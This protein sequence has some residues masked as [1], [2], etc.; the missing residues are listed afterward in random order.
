MKVLINCWF[1]DIANEKLSNAFLNGITELG[2][3]GIELSIDYPLL[4]RCSIPNYLV[5]GLRDRGLILS[6]HLP[7]REIYLASPISE[8]RDAAVR[9]IS[10]IIRQVS[11]L[12]PEYLITHLSTDQAFCGEDDT[13]C[14]KASL[15]SIKHLVKLSEELGVLLAVE[16]VADKCCSGEE[17]LPLILKEFD[18]LR[19]CLDIP[20]I[21]EHRLRYWGVTTSVKEVIN[22]LAPIMFDRLITIHIHG[23]KVHNG[24]AISHIIPSKEFLSSL[25]EG[26]KVKISNKPKY[27]VIEVFRDVNGGP[28]RDINKLR[29]IISYLR[30]W[31]K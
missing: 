13:D 9:T 7:W 2:F 29:W 14:V 27:A 23:L 21:I 25:L 8:V 31:R 10:R 18:R 1:K 6:V 20:H 22:D 24:M 4:F 28:L 17:K 11:R 30:R 3:D 12:G 5:N 15:E 19:I 16:T 26:L